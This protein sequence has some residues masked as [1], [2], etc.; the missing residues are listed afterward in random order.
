[1]SHDSVAVEKLG[2]GLPDRPG[3]GEL[4]QRRVGRHDLDLVGDEPEP[5]AEVDEPDDETLARQGVE[6]EPDRVGA[7]ADAERVDLAARRPGRDAR[8][9][10]EH[11][12]TEDLRL[13]GTEVVGVVL[14]ERGAAGLALAHDLQDPHERRGLPVALG[15]EAVA[16][17]HEALHGDAGELSQSAEV[18]EVRREGGRSL[19]PSRN[20]RR[21]ASMRAA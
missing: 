1:M 20:D 2:R 13:A 18:L 12:R 21:P 6:D 15:A 10:L 11:V 3:H 8:A 9:D 4:R 5:V 16:V 14:H 7:V 19:P 17:G